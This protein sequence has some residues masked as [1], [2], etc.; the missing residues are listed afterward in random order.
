MSIIVIM[1]DDDIIRGLLTRLV[2]SLGDEVLAFEDA[3]LA[4]DAVDF[5][6]VDLI[7]TD[8]RMPMPGDQAVAQLRAK[9]IQL[10]V[11]FL[12]GE[13]LSESHLASLIA[14][15]NCRV[16]AKP[17]RLKELIGAMDEMLL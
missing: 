9:G 14:L 10:P 7:V 12:T 2:A 11:I 16:M 3:Q 17:F 15:D 5:Q 4:L 8:L 6:A 13:F 1:E